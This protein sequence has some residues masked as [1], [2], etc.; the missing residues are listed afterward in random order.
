MGLFSIRVMTVI[1]NAAV[2]PVPVWA[3]PLASL[4]DRLLGRILAWIGVQYSK[5]RSLMA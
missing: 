5:P 1:R 3:R 4:P 2:F